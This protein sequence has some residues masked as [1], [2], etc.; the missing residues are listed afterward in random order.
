[1]L[2]HRAP[3]LADLFLVGRPTQGYWIW[4]AL[5]LTSGHAEAERQLGPDSPAVALTGCIAPHVLQMP[6]SHL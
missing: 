6:F 3:E 1:M 5:L 2:T 4:E